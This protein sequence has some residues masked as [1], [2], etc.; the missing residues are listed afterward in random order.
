MTLLTKGI[1]QSV[2]L[3][4]TVMLVSLGGYLLLFPPEDWSIFWS[5]RIV[6][7][8]LIFFLLLSTF[9]ITIIWAFIQGAGLRQQIH[10]V[11]H[12]LED[13]KL[14]RSTLQ[15]KSPQSTELASFHLKQK[16]FRR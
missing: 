7:I 8:P 11:R 5:T 9:S 10:Y 12:Q 4:L 15:G 3:A 6:D 2:G 16:T 13:M 14:G 1:L